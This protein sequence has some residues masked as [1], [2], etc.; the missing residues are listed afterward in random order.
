VRERFFLKSTYCNKQQKPE[1]PQ[2]FEELGRAG[3]KVISKQEMEQ[4]EKSLE[5]GK[6]D[7][8]RQSIFT[9]ATENIQKSRYQQK[10]S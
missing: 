6:F 7:L 10:V 4:L 1:T 3:T 2:S 8:V 5:K 9:R